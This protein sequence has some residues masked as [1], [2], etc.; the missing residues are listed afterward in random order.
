MTRIKVRTRT[1]TY[2]MTGRVAC[3]VRASS[4]ANSAALTVDLYRALRGPRERCATAAAVDIDELRRADDSPPRRR[5]NNL[6]AGPSTQRTRDRP[7]NNIS[8]S[9]DN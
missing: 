7:F 5:T 4:T 3:L 6:I 8:R 9:G 2:V 1:E